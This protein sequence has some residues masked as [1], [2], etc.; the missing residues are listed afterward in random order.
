[1]QGFFFVKHPPEERERSEQSLA[2]QRYKAFS[3]GCYHQEEKAE[4][5]EA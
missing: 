4:Q 2:H 1:M 3:M 5:S